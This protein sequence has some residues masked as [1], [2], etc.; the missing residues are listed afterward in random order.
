MKEN[1]YYRKYSKKIK[2]KLI[3]RRQALNQQRL[4]LNLICEY[5][6]KEFTIP[7][8]NKNGFKQHVVKYCSGLCEDR[9]GRFRKLWIPKWLFNFYL[10][11]K[12][13]LWVISFKQSKY[14]IF[15]PKRRSMFRLKNT[16]IKNLFVLWH[17]R[18]FLRK[19]LMVR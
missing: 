16:N 13:F 10:D 15:S 18:S 8:M 19:N 7:G 2:Q 4:P 9:T 12:L 5:C 11:K 3:D 1:N 17:P 14:S 6:N